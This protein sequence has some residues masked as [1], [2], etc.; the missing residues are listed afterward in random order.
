MCVCLKMGGWAVAQ[1]PIMLTKLMT[2]LELPG[3]VGLS[4]VLVVRLPLGLE[5]RYLGDNPL[6]LSDGHESS[7]TDLLAGLKK[8][9]GRIR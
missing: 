3:Q 7:I 8:Q 1:S 9:Y 2:G 4:T 5:A 6:L